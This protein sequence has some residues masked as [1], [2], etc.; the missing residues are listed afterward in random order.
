MKGEKR[1]KMLIKLSCLFFIVLSFTGCSSQGLS[2][3]AIVKA[4]LIDIE[5]NEY[6]ASLVMLNCEPSSQIAEI[7][8]TASIYTGISSNLNTAILNA[9]KKQNKSTFYAQNELLFINLNAISKFD[10]I[11]NYFLLD[12]FARPGLTVYLTQTNENGLKEAEKNL[13]K[14]INGVQDINV[15]NNPFTETRI[16]DV[17]V[18]NSSYSAV[19]PN[20]TV[21]AS[22]G[23]FIVDEM[24]V[25][26]SN[27]LIAR[28][29]DNDMAISILLSKRSDNLNINTE[30]FTFKA[31]SIK[32]SNE[33]ID[34]TLYCTISGRIK[35][36]E[37]NNNTQNVNAKDIENIVNEYIINQSCTVFN[38]YF[39]NNNI[40][41]FNWWFEMYGKDKGN[42]CFVSKL[43]M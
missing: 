3:R 2:N 26:S 13:P 35:Q 9:E 18:K 1:V 31:N 33:V 19:F 4:I 40:L 15:L 34:G 42:V 36:F 23:S 25:I 32:I 37:I 41:K 30:D 16:Y 7:K 38:E 10:E 6:K 12:N 29:K 43:V 27:N 22:N 17:M 14:L 8:E 20:L 24:G 5:D 21:N 39:E 11:V 28:L